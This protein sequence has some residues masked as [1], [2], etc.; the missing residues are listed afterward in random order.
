ML[1]NL[2]VKGLDAAA[3]EL[4][5]EPWE[6]G[7]TARRAGRSGGAQAMSVNETVIALLRPKPDLALLSGEPADARAS[8]RAAVDAPDGIGAV[9]S[10]TSEVPLPAAGTWS[11]P[12]RGS[13]RAD[14]VLTAPGAGVPLLFIEV[15]N[16]TEDAAV[17]ADKFTKYLRFFPRRVKDTDGTETPL[18]RLRWSAPPDPYTD[19]PHPP[20]LLVFNQF[21]ARPARNTMRQVAALTRPLWDGQPVRSG[22]Y[23]LYDGKIPIVATTL[24]LLREHGPA[25]WRFGR[26]DRQPL[27]DAIGNPRG[28]RSWRAAERLRRPA[29]RLTGSNVGAWPN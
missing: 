26:D 20:V 29:R 12:A 23:H 25:F 4:R 8:A 5:R 17:I 28:A 22:S 19:R 10:Y 1:R 15:D 9:A 21:G 6:M 18:W 11:S 24:E 7:G 16:C 13:A 2:T 3:E 14:L 27:T